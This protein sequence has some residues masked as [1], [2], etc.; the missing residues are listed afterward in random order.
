MSKPSLKTRVRFGLGSVLLVIPVGLLAGTASAFFLWAL[1]QVSLTRW[2]NPWLLFLLPLAGVASGWLFARFGRSVEAGNDLIIDEIHQPGGGVPL[3]LTPLILLGTLLT[4]LCG[5]SVGREGTAVQMG[6]SL[7]HAYGRWLGVAA[8]R[9]H[10]LL[11]AGVAAGFA[12][13][14]GTPF[15][16]ALFAMEVLIA[17]RID[18]RATLP[19]FAAALVGHFTC[20]AWG[21]QHSTYAIAL[22]DPARGAVDFLL[23]GKV[24]LA[25][26]I[27]GTV[28]RGFATLTHALKD[29]FRRVVASPLLRPALGGVFVLGLTLA[30]GTRDYL[31]L[32]VSSPDKHAVTILSAFGAGGAEPWSWALKF[33]FTAITIGSGFKGGEVTPL[34]FIGATLGNALAWVFHA[35][36]DL[37]AGIGF[38][39]VFA[40][41][42]HTPLA[43][44]VMGIELFGSNHA[45]AFAIACFI[46]H[47]AAGKSS[48]FR[49]QRRPL[50]I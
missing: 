36:V 44:A 42:T 17:G 30:L 28:A 18:R 23:L 20:L 7:A 12:A 50:T 9:R 46:A 5:G 35:P 38:L 39:A 41:A 32:G 45:L 13:V 47:L 37:F 22:G 24:A 19:V 26:L 10:I 15:A 6:G 11:M 25:A 43:C 4:H 21:A 1:D 31:G 14:F 48:I 2:Q 8:E 40:G 49:A 3:R 27:F 29:G 33:L 34:F 16:G